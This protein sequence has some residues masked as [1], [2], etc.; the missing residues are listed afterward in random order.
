LEITFKWSQKDLV[1]RRTASCGRTDSSGAVGIRLGKSASWR[2]GVRDAE[3]LTD[4]SARDLND[5]SGA[6]DSLHTT[7][8]HIQPWLVTSARK[9]DAVRSCDTD[10]RISGPLAVALSDFGNQWASRGWSPFIGF[11]MSAILTLFVA[12]TIFTGAFAVR[13]E[14]S[15]LLPGPSPYH[16]Y[17]SV[18]EASVPLQSCERDACP[19]LPKQV[20]P[21]CKGSRCTQF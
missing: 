12:P 10:P 8:T 18:H 13:C 15:L 20:L 9:R 3:V 14:S 21:T 5:H 16:L 11:G 4:G 19:G 2:M 1:P 6:D 7:H 17:A